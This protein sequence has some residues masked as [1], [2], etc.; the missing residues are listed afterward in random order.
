MVATRATREATT[1]EGLIQVGDVRLWHRITGEGDPVVQI[2]GA[3]F[4]HFNFDPGHARALAALPGDR[5][6]HARVRR[7]GPPDP[8]LRH[9]GLGGRRRRP[10]RRPR[11]R[12]RA[13]PRDVD[14]RDDRDRLR[15][16]V[17]RADAIGRDQL[18]RGEARAER[19]A[20]LQELDRHR[21]A[22]PGR[23]RKPAPRRADHVAG[24]L[25]P[26]PRRAGR[27]R[28]RRPDPGDPPRL[29]PGRGVHGG[30]PGDVRHG[31]SRLAAEDHRRRRSS[32]AATR[33]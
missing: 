14:G 15:R 3:G 8:G 24:A 7:L 4:G 13:R 31:H 10:A 28:A 11:P 2:H 19:A 27:G 18:R 6:R 12:P 17:P 32:S 1:V 25:A 23:A 16:Q 26:L 21:D 29:E 9:G 22:R 20:D 5:L 30:V 33:T